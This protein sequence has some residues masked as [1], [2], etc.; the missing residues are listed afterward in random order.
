MKVLVCGGRTFGSIPNRADIP[1]ELRRERQKQSDFVS[2]TLDVMFQFELPELL[3]EGGAPGADT[4]G[5]WWATKVGVPIKTFP[6]DWGK[7]GKSAGSIRNQRM[8][9]EGQPD[10]VVAF[11]G[12]NG[13]ADMVA[14]A[15]R[16][17]VEVREIA[18]AADNN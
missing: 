2:D 15:K 18:Y 3:I 4:C 10:L 14:K 17:G 12:G 8:L 7:H 1:D 9:F 6:A 11:P 16:A 5:M 13:T